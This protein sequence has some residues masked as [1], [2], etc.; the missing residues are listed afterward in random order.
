M[1][2]FVYQVYEEVNVENREALLYNYLQD[3]GFYVAEHGLRYV[4]NSDI[5]LDR[6]VIAGTFSQEYVPNIYEV[7]EDRSIVPRED[8]EPYDRTFFAFDFSTRAFLIQNKKYPPEN[9]KPG[10]TLDRLNDIF[11]SAFNELFNSNCT[12]VPVLLPEGNESFLR[13][14]DTHRVIEVKVKEI[15]NGRLLGE[16]VILSADIAES[17]AMKTVWN[18]DISL[19]D[20][21]H[22]RTSLEGSLNDSLICKAAINSPGAV[23][24]TMRYFDPEEDGFVTKKRSKLDQFSVPSIDRNTESITAFNEIT[25]TVAMNRRILRNMRQIRT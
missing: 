1:D 25:N 19:T 18:N 5:E 21:I 2:F 14:F 15:N 20:F 3:T 22:L 17:E 6:G 8:V 4:I 12:F 7:E 13:L 16:E 9:L 23:I 24:D 10:R 11:N